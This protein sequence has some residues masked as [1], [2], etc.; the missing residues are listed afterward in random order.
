MLNN[1][2]VPGIGDVVVHITGLFQDVTEGVAI[3]GCSD[4]KNTLRP[5]GFEMPDPKAP[6]RQAWEDE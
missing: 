3:I 2:L 4:D 1:L 6:K 5:G